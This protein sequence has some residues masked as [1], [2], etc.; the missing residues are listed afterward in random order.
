[1][2]LPAESSGLS[3]GDVPLD[4]IH[5]VDASSGRLAPEAAEANHAK[6]FKLTPSNVVSDVLFAWV[7]WLLW[8]CLG[9]GAQNVP[10][11]LG[12]RDRSANTTATF[13]KAYEQDQELLK[14]LWK[15]FG[16]QLLAMG[17]WKVVWTICTWAGAFYLLE[18]LM[19]KQRMSIAVSLLITTVVSA[20]AIQVQFYYICF[21]SLIPI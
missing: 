18:Q 3:A 16:S 6:P 10:V 15:V 8:R 11:Q 17:L 4:S 20:V 12:T 19:L 9:Q 14:A 13:R 5:A 1:M 21:R 7:F 2:A